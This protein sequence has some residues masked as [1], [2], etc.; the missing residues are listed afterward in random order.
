MSNGKLA[1]SDRTLKLI[2]KA[3]T[4]N[5]KAIKQLIKESRPYIESVINLYDNKTRIPEKDELR[6][7]VM[8]GFL[9]SITHYDVKKGT[10]FLYFARIWMKKYIFQHSPDYR[11]IRL[12]ANQQVFHDKYSIKYLTDVNDN[13]IAPD[14]EEFK[15]YSSIESSDSL[16]FSDYETFNK[17]SNIYELPSN[18]F[19]SASLEAFNESENKET[20]D[21]LKKEI[22][23][24]LLMFNENEQYILEHAFGLNN[25]EILT[26][27]Q[28]AKN[29]G[30]TKVNVA[31]KL[32]K[33]IKTMRH[34]SISNKLL[35][36]V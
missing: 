32:N 26:L 27:E 11:L 4:G 5:S 13:Y 36:R 35:G 25:T 28:I 12:P 1:M 23:I 18:L 31:S 33:C 30:V 17:E 6:S 2:K 19:Y 15:Q 20:I 3:K 7:I 29:T 9:E 24:I 34:S 14:E 8:E 16:F 22:A 21:L 10:T